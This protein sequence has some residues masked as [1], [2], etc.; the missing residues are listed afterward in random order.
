MFEGDIGDLVIV[1]LSALAAAGS[2]V[3]F[4]L[5]MLNRSEKRERYQ[6]IIEKR[7][8]DLFQQAKEQAENPAAK[9]SISARDSMATMFMSRL[10]MACLT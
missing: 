2:F 10:R 4:A 3:A 1:V 6:N 8:K 9:Q 7:R 5:P